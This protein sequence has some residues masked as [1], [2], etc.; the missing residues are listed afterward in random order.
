MKRAV[1]ISGSS[2]TVSKQSKL[3]DMLRRYGD[4]VRF[5][6]K[7]LWQGSESRYQDFGDTRLSARL[8]TAAHRQARAICLTTRQAAK[9]TGVTPSQ[10]CFTKNTATLDAKNVRIRLE[11]PGDKRFDLFVDV[12]VL[13]NEWLTLPCRATKRLWYWLGK[14][15]ASLAIGAQF[16]EDRLILWVDIPELPTLTGDKELGI[17]IGVNK[18][19]TTSDGEKIGTELNNE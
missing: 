1:L 7:P 5:Y 18:L 3:S 15:G 6:L 19:I 8:K 2:W 17:D 10:P 12:R 9:A 4:A 11:P 16:Y 13:N 14:P